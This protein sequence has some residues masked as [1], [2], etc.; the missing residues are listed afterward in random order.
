MSQVTVIKSSSLADGSVTHPSCDSGTH[1]SAPFEVESEPHPVASGSA[2]PAADG[3][4]LYYGW[5]MLLMA[6]AAAIASSPGQTFG[7]SIFNEPLRIEL[8]LSHGQ[9]GFAY[10]LGTL[11]GAAPII[12]IGAQ[13]DRRGIRTTMLGV[14]CLFSM[15]CVATSFAHNWLQLVLCFTF[16]RMLGPGALSLLS[17]NVLPFW[18]SRRLGT[19]EG[20]R[21]TAMALAMA[22]IPPVNIWLVASFGWRNAF[23]IL[24]GAVFLL[25]FPVFYRFFRCDPSELGQRIDGQPVKPSPAERIDSPS[26]NRRR[27]LPATEVITMPPL[28]LKETLAT[29]VFWLVLGGTSL[30]G[31]IQTGVFFNLVPIFAEAGLN[32]Q[33]VASMLMLFAIS[34]AV[35]QVVGGWLA[36]RCPP[37]LL[38]ITGMLLFSGGLTLLWHAHSAT[39]ILAAGVVLGGAQGTYFSSAQPL[40]A[41]YFGRHNLGKLRGIQMATNVAISSLGP[42][43]VGLCRD[44]SGGFNPVL[45]LFMLLPIPMAIASCWLR[46]PG[47][48]DHEC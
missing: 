34:L 7:I 2:A 25:L 40:W 29:S 4:K 42:L 12:W 11:L 10:M 6:M 44:L 1:D 22:I 5:Y 9:L 27:S 33:H 47:N 18:F 14:I 41:R 17:G 43:L 8:G 19:V 26:E 3:P 38:L 23:A 30:F 35:H 31:M 21:Q 20:F 48:T 45:L 32:D 36:D 39:S 16:L 37:R 13:M 46:R 28:S 15:A 24:G